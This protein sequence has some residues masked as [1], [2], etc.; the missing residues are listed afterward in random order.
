MVRQ[1]DWVTPRLS[2]ADWTGPSSWTWRLTGEAGAPIVQQ[3]VAVNPDDPMLALVRDLYRNLWRMDDTSGQPLL[4]RVGDFVGDRLLGEVGRALAAQTPVTVRVELP[5]ELTTLLAVPFELAPLGGVRFCYV[6]EGAVP[7]PAPSESARIL[8]V[9]ALPGESS[10]LALS[11]ERR[12][13]EAQFAGYGNA[14]ELRTL[15]YGVTRAVLREALS[16]SAGWDVVH[17]AGHG[18]VGQLFLEGD[19]DQRDLVSA[20]ELLELL[21]SASR[22]PGL[23]VLSACESGAVRILRRRRPHG[24]P[25]QLVQQTAAQ[26]AAATDNLGYQIAARLGCAVVAMRYPVDDDFTVSLGRHLYDR[27]LVGGQPVDQALSGAVP[28]AAAGRAPLSAATPILFGDPTFRLRP[29]GIVAGS[30]TTLAADPRVPARFV[31]RTAVMVRL[32]RSPD[33]VVVLT[34]MPG[35]GKTTCLA[36]AAGWHRRRGRPVVWHDVHP[37]ETPE[38]LIQTLAAQVTDPQAL[39]LIDNIDTAPQICST[40]ADL[41]RSG[42]AQWMMAARQ[43]ISDFEQATMVVPLLTRTESELLAREVQ[44]QRDIDTNEPQ[45]GAYR[46][47]PWLIGRGHP[48][49]IEGRQDGVDEAR[50]WEVSR[51]SPSTGRPCRPVTQVRRSQPGPR[52]SPLASRPHRGCCGSSC[53]VWRLPT[54]AN[55]SCRCCGR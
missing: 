35:I 6:P 19:D 30:S 29:P 55:R 52:A 3:R 48:G 13:L 11:R 51:R 41:S 34:G 45:N 49:L 17:I 40:L 4:T 27:L 5:A 24:R 25:E 7:P 9:F 38:R 50:A 43:R 32:L 44:E 22:V 18:R 47:S 20:A 10:A 15:Q 12:D 33:H 36:E 54:G 16:D 8:A 26:P 39:I 53:R 14:V 42:R 2:I 1:H 37:G 23:V 21:A 28:A 46:G 31:G